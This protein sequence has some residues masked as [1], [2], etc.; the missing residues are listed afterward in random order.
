MKIN[1]KAVGMDREN[2]PWQCP[3]HPDA[4]I[5]HT[6]NRTQFV[7]ADGYPRG[8]SDSNHQYW[9]NACGKELASERKPNENKS[10]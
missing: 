3:E 4:M 9:C 7:Y 5:K 1:R 6:W 10:A 8:G 2:L